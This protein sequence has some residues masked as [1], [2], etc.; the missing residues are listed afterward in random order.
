LEPVTRARLHV[1]AVGALGDQALPALAARLPEVLL[2][3][4]VAVR[5]VPD[6]AVEVE[7]PAQQRLALAERPAG[8][9]VA[10]E[11]EDVEQVVVDGSPA[12]LELREARAGALECDH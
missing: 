10:V 11:A 12:T 8:H 7:R 3:V 9:L 1:R 4:A 6:G 5:R 2:A